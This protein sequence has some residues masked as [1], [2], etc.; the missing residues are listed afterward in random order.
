MIENRPDAEAG[1]ET[2]EFAD[3]IRERRA[4]LGLSLSAFEKRSIDPITGTQVKSG[5]VYRL[6]TGES[7]IPPR[8]AQLRALR[9][10]TGL[11]LHQ[12]QDAAAAQFFGIE[13]VWAESGEASALVRRTEKLTEDQR[14]QL[15]RLIDAFAPPGQ[16]E[17]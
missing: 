11:P 15:L 17:H 13:R 5:W 14:E 2:T 3:L 10:A 12:L 9:E 7:V 8:T 4:A 6:E 16:D 1:A